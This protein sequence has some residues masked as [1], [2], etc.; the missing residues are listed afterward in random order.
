MKPQN[1]VM[2]L[3]FVNALSNEAGGYR[4][5][6]YVYNRKGELSGKYFKK[7]LPPLELEVLK[8]D[9]DYTFEFSEPYTL[10]I[11]GLKYA[12]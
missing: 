9:S 2:Q 4:N 5:T 12:F 3:F 8:L 10:E 1:A 6:T 11:E 7:H